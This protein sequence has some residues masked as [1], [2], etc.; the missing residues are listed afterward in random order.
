MGASDRRL[1]LVLEIRGHQAPRWSCYVN[2]SCLYVLI[3]WKYNNLTSIPNQISS[4][5]DDVATAVLAARLVPER[6]AKR[7]VFFEVRIVAYD[8][9]LRG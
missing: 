7:A 4:H 6:A 2:I 9:V 3:D 1:S 8:D 5:H